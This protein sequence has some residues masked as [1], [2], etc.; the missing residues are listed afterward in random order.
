M[1]KCIKVLAALLCPILLIGCATIVSGR[2]QRVSVS[3]FPS[4]AKVIVNGAEQQSPC[5]IML[6]RAFPSYQIII[7]KE[8]YKTYTY[9]LTRGINGWL[10]GNILLG[11]IIGVVIDCATSSAYAFSPDNITINLTELDGR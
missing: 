1:K 11:G 6:D 8:G 10:F 7:Q 4:D 5:V 2:T 9:N 3:T